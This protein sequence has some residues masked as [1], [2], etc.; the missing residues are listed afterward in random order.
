MF[1]IDSV[2]WNLYR[3]KFSI[4]F[5]KFRVMLDKNHCML[6]IYKTKFA[7]FDAPLML[8]NHVNNNVI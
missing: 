4:E 5:K 8:F 1:N 6:R 7:G 3:L 2:Q